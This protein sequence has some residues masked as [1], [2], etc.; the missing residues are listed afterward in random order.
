MEFFFSKVF[1]FFEMYLKACKWSHQSLHI[2]LSVNIFSPSH[3]NAWVQVVELGGTQS[4]LFVFLPVSRLDL[5]LQQLLLTALY[6][7]FLPL[8]QSDKRIYT[9]AGVTESDSSGSTYKAVKNVKPVDC[10]KNKKKQN[11]KQFF[12]FLR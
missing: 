7:G 4:D 8:H 5:Q 9:K 11:T 2:V 12:F 10:K 6:C 3:T 1:L